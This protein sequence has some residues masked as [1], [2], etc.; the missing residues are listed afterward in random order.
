MAEHA[1]EYEW[2]G[3]GDEAEIVLYAPDT[4]AFER[5]L[6]AA[7]LPGVESPV[8]A[9]ASQSGF[10]WAAASTTHVAP[11]LI[12][13]PLRG[14]LLIA[15]TRSENL[16][17]GPR[18]LV[19]RMLRD[20][21]E[22]G[23]RLPSLNEAGVGRLC[24]SGARAAAEDGLI[25][26]DDL[27]LLGALQGDPDALGRR[28]LAA[29]PREWG[30]VVRPELGVVMGVL[31]TEGAESLGLETGALAIVVRVDAGDLGRLA[32]AAHR[33]RILGRTEDFGARLDLPSVPVERGEAEDLV[34]A[35]YA[36]ANF[37]DGRAARTVRMLRRLLGDATGGLDIRAAW[38]AG[39]IE[40][41]DGRVVH[42]RGLAAVEGSDVLV[43]GNYAAAGTGNM[44]SSAPPFGAMEDEGV[45]PWE[46]AGLLE[47]LAAFDP[48]EG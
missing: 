21:P 29:G 27:P 20:L 28:A 15:G 10:G 22:A 34:A 13:A 18:E 23:S 12:S 14:L 24:E 6:P 44:W 45:W 30:E 46:E 48:P 11:D 47:R 9:A 39:G 5:V 8:Y 41:R 33:E 7:S 43:S 26:E 35:V 25:E 17:V 1:A 4:A 38:T 32:L 3:D 36:A 2:R 40:E 37:A 42:R 16:G 19:N 31:D